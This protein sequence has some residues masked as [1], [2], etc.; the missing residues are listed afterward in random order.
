[1]LG[2]AGCRSAEEIRAAVAETPPAQRSD[3]AAFSQILAKRGVLTWYQAAQLRQGKA[4]GLLVGGHIILDRIGQGGMGTVYQAW[5]QRLGRKVA[6]KVLSPER[7]VKPAALKRF[8][9]EVQVAARLNHPNIVAA[10]D[11]DRDA[12]AQFLVMEY[13]DGVDLAHHVKQHGP[14]P[15]NQAVAAIIQAAQGLD[16]AHAYGIIHRDIKP[17]NLLRDAQGAVKILDLGLAGFEEPPDGSNDLTKSGTVLGT[18]DYMPPEQAVSIR[19]VDRRAD[20]YALGCT[21]YFLLTGKS[22]YSGTSVMEKLLA[23]RD[24]PIPSLRAR[25]TDVPEALDQVYQRMVAKRPEDRYGTMTDVIA[26]VHDALAHAGRRTGFQ[27]APPSSRRLLGGTPSSRGLPRVALTPAAPRR[28]RRRLLLVGFI[29]ALVLGVLVGGGGVRWFLRQR[30]A[31]P[32]PTA[33]AV[34]PSTVTPLPV[35]ATA[36][37]RLERVVAQLK[38]LNPGFDGAVEHHVEAGKL[39][40]LSFRTD[41]V[42]DLTP[43][44]ELTDLRSLTATGSTVGAGKLASL[45]ALAALPLETLNCLNNPQLEDLT[46]L[47]NMPLK[48]LF[49]GNTRVASLAPLQGRPLTHLSLAGARG[50]RDLAPLTGMA[51]QELNLTSTGVNDINPLTGMPLVRLEC[52][53]TNV[54]DYA[55][56]KDMPLKEVSVEFP[57]RDQARMLELLRSVKTLE[58]INNRKAAEYLKMLNE[59]VLGA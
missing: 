50:V 33:A 24:Q 35:S 10:I 46:P 52:R 55:I 29:V 18:C 39:T 1:M 41:S 32:A 23:H 43:L 30:P 2:A 54:R 42:A 17:S 25:R 37:Q 12:E 7:M 26:A 38:A 15:L 13:V 27:A 6:V 3:P 5:H 19:D 34:A 28:R 20:V 48:R 16:H 21:L 8:Q 44:S 57:R 51:L 59:R 40:E 14:L 53:N 36:G 11:V 22:V 4:A 49:L 56:I 45:T 9:R 47:Q 58:T 31:A